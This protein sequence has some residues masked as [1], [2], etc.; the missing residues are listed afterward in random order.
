MVNR[1]S[2]PGARLDLVPAG[3]EQLGGSGQ[4]GASGQSD[5]ASGL[6]GSSVVETGASEYALFKAGKI[7]LNEYLE[8]SVDRAVMHLQGQ[9]PEQ[10]IEA[11]RQVLRAG[12]ADDPELSALAARVAQSA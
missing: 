8:L 10:Q 4:L 1:R 12:L 7:D 6:D 11:M 5:L 2:D 9:I 3:A